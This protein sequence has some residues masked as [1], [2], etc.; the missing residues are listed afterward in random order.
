M[1]VDGNC[2]FLH[3]VD[4]VFVVVGAQVCLLPETTIYSPGFLNDALSKVSLSAGD[5]L[6]KVG[7]MDETDIEGNALGDVVQYG[8]FILSRLD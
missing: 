4:S 7:P 3:I 6:R 2:N 1:A 5:L 8:V